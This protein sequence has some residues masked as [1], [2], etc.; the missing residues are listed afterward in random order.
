MKNKGIYKKTYKRLLFYKRFFIQNNL[1]YFAL[2]SKHSST[3]CL[4]WH[5]CQ[6]TAKLMPVYRLHAALKFR[7]G[8]ASIHDLLKG[9]AI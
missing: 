6:N 4:H 3:T 8:L 5:P 1:S 2:R 9:N 7:F